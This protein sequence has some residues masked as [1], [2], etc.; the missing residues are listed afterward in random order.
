M[1]IYSQLTN[2]LLAAKVDADSEKETK[3]KGSGWDKKDGRPKKGGQKAWR[4]PL[5]INWQNVLDKT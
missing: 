1:P 4:N 2:E 5:G 3:G